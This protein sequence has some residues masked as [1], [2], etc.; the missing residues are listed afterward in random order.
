MV[1]KEL[2]KVIKGEI[3]RQV[4]ETDTSGVMIMI[5]HPDGSSDKIMINSGVEE[6]KF[7]QHLKTI[8]AYLEGLP[9]MLEKKKVQIQLD[10]YAKHEEGIKHITRNNLIVGR[11]RPHLTNSEIQQIETMFKEEF[12]EFWSSD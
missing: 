4:R 3:L 9:H 5:R 12:A 8:Y 6:S 10:I 11:I 2:V 1:D 7:D